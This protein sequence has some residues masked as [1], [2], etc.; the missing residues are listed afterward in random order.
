MYCL[1]LSLYKLLLFLKI[2]KK[3]ERLFEN[4][5]N[6]NITW[7]YNLKKAKKKINQTKIAGTVAK[8]TVYEDYFKFKS[9]NLTIKDI[10]KFWRL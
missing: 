2:R 5:S 6:T 7:G 9:G 8:S 4:Y 10:L 3:I 1:R